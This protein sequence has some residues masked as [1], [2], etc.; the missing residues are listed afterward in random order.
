MNTLTKKAVLLSWLFL[1]PGSSALAWNEKDTYWEMAYLAAHVADWGQTRDIASHCGAGLYYETNP[2]L[3]RCP[4]TAWVN[5][6]F[7]GTALLH[8]GVANALPTKYRRLF[9]G[10]TLAME[11][12]Y[13]NSNA[14]IG[15]QVNF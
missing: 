4:S 1:V 8:M 6:Y 11:L 9:Q 10:G 13:V 7:I 3:G 2:V 14:K 5:T 15:L 12:N